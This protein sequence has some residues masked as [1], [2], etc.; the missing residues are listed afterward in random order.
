MDPTMSTDF[1]ALPF[2]LQ[3]SD[4]AVV[5][6]YE[7]RDGQRT[8]VPYIPHRPSQRAAVDDPSTWGLFPVAVDAV[9]DGKADGPG[10]V[11][12]A[13][14]VGIDLDHCIAP[15]TG[16]LDPAA[17]QIVQEFDS[18]A[19]LSPSGLGVHIWIRSAHDIKGRRRHGVEVYGD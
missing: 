14:L 2:E 8:K 18:Y 15:D 1:D 11:L 9:L 19:E 3:A 12:G 13:G 4:R 6:N 7:D 16:A 17:H 10:I 5:W